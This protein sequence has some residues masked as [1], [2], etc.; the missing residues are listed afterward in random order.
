MRLRMPSVVAAAVAMLVVA[1]LP[2]TAGSPHFIKS[3]TYA[4]Q[5][6]ADLSV[7]FKE[8][9][10]SSGSSETV[11]VSGAAATTYECVNGG[12]QNPSASNKRTMQSAVKK[13]GTFTADTNGNINGSLTLSPPTASQLGFHCPAGQTTTFVSVTYSNLSITDT[14]SGAS[15]SI[16]GTWSYTNPSAP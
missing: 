4:T 2:A 7:H 3:A 5:S 10:L 12:G 9:G 11:E 14:T 1:A 16:P 15:L 6:G 8:A 13:S